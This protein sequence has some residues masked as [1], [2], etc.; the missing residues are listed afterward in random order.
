MKGWAAPF[1]ENTPYDPTVTF[2]RMANGSLDGGRDFNVSIREQC[3]GPDL[4]KMNLSGTIRLHRQ[5]VR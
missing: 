5:V 2:N 4:S 1:L 3:H